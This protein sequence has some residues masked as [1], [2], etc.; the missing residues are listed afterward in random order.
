MSTKTMGMLGG[1][2]TNPTIDT[3]R[4]LPG[5]S[6]FIKSPRAVSVEKPEKGMYRSAYSE[7]L[8]LM[9]FHN[10]SCRYRGT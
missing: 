4:F 8:F 10:E 1:I 2:G 9:W 3:L 6:H 7:E 5:A